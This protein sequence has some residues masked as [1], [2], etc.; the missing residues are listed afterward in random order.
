MTKINYYDQA[1]GAYVVSRKNIGSPKSKS[2]NIFISYLVG[3]YC[4]HTHPI[5]FVQAIII[6][7]Q[8]FIVN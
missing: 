3:I 6:G 4:F 1:I 8:Y 5:F 2:I 7:W